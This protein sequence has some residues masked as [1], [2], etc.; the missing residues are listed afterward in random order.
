[1]LLFDDVLPAFPLGSPLTS[2]TGSWGSCCS[3]YQRMK[4]WL[5]KLVKLAKT[6]KFLH[7]NVLLKMCD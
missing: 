3:S 6:L 4:F 7:R 5:I 1:M 2:W